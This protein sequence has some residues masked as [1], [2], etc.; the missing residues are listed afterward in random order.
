MPVDRPQAI[1]P[2][3]QV[4][5][6]GIRLRLSIPA[7]VIY[8]CDSDMAYYHAKYGRLE[9]NWCGP[10]C[11]PGCTE[12]GWEDLTAGFVGSGLKVEIKAVELSEIVDADEADEDNDMPL[13][14]WDICYD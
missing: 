5:H 11:L 13:G 10:A 3:D 9:G 4:S 14:D 6:T 1:P 7:G 2:G 12:H 8:D